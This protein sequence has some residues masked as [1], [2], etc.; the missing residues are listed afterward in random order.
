MSQL[1]L[2]CSSLH[3]KLHQVLFIFL[4][5]TAKNLIFTL[6]LV[7]LSMNIFSPPFSDISTWK[8]RKHTYLLGVYPRNTP[9]TPYFFVYN[10]KNETFTFHPDLWHSKQQLYFFYSFKPLNMLGRTLF[11]VFFRFKHEFSTVFC[12]LTFNCIS[13]IY[14]VAF[15]LRK[16]SFVLWF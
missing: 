4:F 10:C 8:S 2:T 12:S 3:S 6:F 16:R 1:Y 15:S 13:G 7:F 5:I 11:V 14:L 9:I